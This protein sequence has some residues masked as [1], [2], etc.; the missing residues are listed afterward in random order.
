[1]FNIV[2]NNT[3]ETKWFYD[4][5]RKSN[6]ITIDEENLEKVLENKEYKEYTKP[7]AKLS[8]RF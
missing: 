2:I 8:Y 3:A 5:H 4:S 6:F 7:I 1:M